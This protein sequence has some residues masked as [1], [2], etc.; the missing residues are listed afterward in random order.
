MII[1]EK[2]NSKQSPEVNVK[3]TVTNDEPLIRKFAYSYYR[4]IST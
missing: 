4:R 3:I 1:F 2:N